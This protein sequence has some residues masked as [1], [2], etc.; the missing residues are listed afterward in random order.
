MKSFLENMSESQMA[1]LKAGM[2]SVI[3]EADVVCCAGDG[4]A[5][6]CCSDN[7]TIGTGKETVEK[8]LP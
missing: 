7:G 6:K 5:V 1:E 4:Y 3:S 2:A 8:E